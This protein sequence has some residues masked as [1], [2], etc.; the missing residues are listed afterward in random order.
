LHFY[1]GKH[2]EEEMEGE[3]DDEEDS[4]G[5]REGEAPPGNQMLWNWNS[6]NY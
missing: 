3:E 2:A 6:P 4:G 1:N 5:G